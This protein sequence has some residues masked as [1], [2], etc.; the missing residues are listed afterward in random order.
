MSCYHGSQETRGSLGNGA[1]SALGPL[2][3]TKRKPRKRAKGHFSTDAWGPGKGKS[4]SVERCCLRLKRRQSQNLSSTPLTKQVTKLPEIRRDK[5]SKP[6][7]A[8]KPRITRPPLSLA[9]RAVTAFSARRVRRPRFAVQ[10]DEDTSCTKT[11][12]FGCNVGLQVHK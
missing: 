5:E 9:S 4:S 1:P 3:D 11:L 8:W 12:G 10:D 7:A 2:R 6:H